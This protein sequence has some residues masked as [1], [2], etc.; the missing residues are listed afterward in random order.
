MFNLNSFNEVEFN[1]YP[2]SVGSFKLFKNI[3]LDS[4]ASVY[5][6]VYIGSGQLEI[7]K[8]VFNSSGVSY[9]PVYTGR[10]ILSTKNSDL[11]S[12]GINTLEGFIY[13]ENLYIYDKSIENLYIYEIVNN[14]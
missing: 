3:V 1:H 14:G 13:K 2:T 4:K 8:P 12:V 10:L 6:P 11:N 5:I 7:R 9:I